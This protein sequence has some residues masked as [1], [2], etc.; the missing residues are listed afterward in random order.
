MN[1]PPPKRPPLN[2]GADDGGACDDSGSRRRSTIADASL[3]FGD[4]HNDIFGAA[5][6]ATDM[7]LVITDPLQT[8]NPIV[9]ANNA[10]L[11]M[12][13]YP[14]EEIVGRNCRFLQG[15]ETDAGSVAEIRLALA[16][17]RT[18]ST[19]ILNYRKDG[20]SFWSALSISP[21]FDPTGRL[22]YFLAWQLDVSRRR[23]AEDA[24]RQAR[25]ME[26]MGRL[27]GSIAHDFNNLLQV[28]TGYLDLI[29]SGL[30]KPEINRD[31]LL[32][33]IGNAR[34]AADRAAHLTNQLLSYARKR[35]LEGSV[36]NLNAMVSATQDLMIRALGDDVTM[37]TA[38]AADL[39]NCRIDP[40]QAEMALLNIIVHARDA[41]R[42]R[43]SKH[44]VVETCNVI[45]HREDLGRYPS[46]GP[47]RYAS[48]TINDTGSGLSAT[49]VEQMMDPFLAAKGDGEEAVQGLAMVAG[50]AKQFGGCAHIQSK[51]DVGTTV[52]IYVPAVSDAVT[53]QILTR[54]RALDRPGRETILIVEPRADVAELARLI[55][56]HCGYTILQRANGAEALAVIDSE[57]H[58]DLLFVDLM[59]P[60]DLDGVSLARLAKRRRKTLKVL[61]TTG[62]AEAAPERSDLGGAEFD[63]LNK[64]Y[65]R[66]DL[67]RKIRLVLDASTA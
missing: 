36:L 3:S 61:L 18:I 29:G 45:V 16:D 44:V 31:K 40:E 27:T 56:D 20:C 37:T 15:P 39:W 11:D 7:S 42:G 9:F 32:R 26:A 25:K 35:K 14:R 41:M 28:V 6:D 30:Q 22:V 5:V 2:E 10:F 21:I 67:M 62:H 49:A 64:P 23:A 48:L 43:T 51:E 13:G 65:G 52:R 66:P 55:L 46:I 19:E 47:G 60:G 1:V 59:L 4:R 54:M 53:P 58:V 50:F 63:I 38:P 12:T 34:A 24:L 33:S 8:D 17:R 57:R